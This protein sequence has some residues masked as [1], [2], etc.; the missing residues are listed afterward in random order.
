MKIPKTCSAAREAWHRC[1]DD[2]GIDPAVD[3]HLASCDDCRRYAAGMI[4]IVDLLEELR[5]ATGDMT[6]STPF[7]DP[8]RIESRTLVH[9]WKV[10][11]APIRI[12]AAIMMIVGV[13]WLYLA[14]RVGPS[15][16]WT[17]VATPSPDPMIPNPSSK[18][19]SRVVIAGITLQDRSADRWLAVARPGV[20]PGVRTFLLYPRSAG[21]SR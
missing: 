4:R 2:G 13:G 5:A 21:A 19:D 7:R 3:R 9:R 18:P 11:V 16:T 20:E 15:N 1:R 10:F 17:P 8:I 6:P 12:A 14:T